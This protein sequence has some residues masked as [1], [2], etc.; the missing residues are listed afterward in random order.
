MPVPLH[1]DACS[2]RVL[3]NDRFRGKTVACP[4]CGRP[5]R[6]SS[7]STSVNPSKKSRTLQERENKVAR[8]AGFLQTVSTRMRF[9][10]AVFGV[11]LVVIS[12]VAIV[13]WMKGGHQEREAS[14]LVAV[15]EGRDVAAGRNNPVVEISD[16]QVPVDDESTRSD[17][18][19]ALSSVELKSDD[20]DSESSD[21]GEV[22]TLNDTTGP[23]ES[24]VPRL[25]TAGSPRPD[26]VRFRKVPLIDHVT[27]MAMSE[28]GSVLLTLHQSS[29]QVS[30]YDVLL[31]KVVAV[32]PTPSPRSILIRGDKAYV[33]NG[34]EP[35][36]RVYSRSKDWQEVARLPIS[37]KNIVH[38]SAA[39][40]PFFDGELLV[41][42][43]GDDRNASYRDAAV[44][45]LDSNTRDVSR[46]AA[47]S[48]ASVSFDG[49]TVLTQGSFNLSPSGGIGIYDHDE[50]VF[51]DAN[52]ISKGGMLQ[53]PFLSQ[54]LPG[55]YWTA[56]TVVF[57]GTPI[58]PVDADYGRLV[59]PDLSQRVIY[60]LHAKSLHALELNTKMTELGSRPVFYPSPFDEFERVYH[61]LYRT[62][63]YLLDHPVAYTHGERTC[64]FVLCA[65]GGVVLAAETSA[66]RQPKSDEFAQMIAEAKTNALE[67][68]TARPSMDNKSATESPGGISSGEKPL[69]DDVAGKNSAESMDPVPCR[70]TC[71]C[72]QVSRRA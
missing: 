53:T 54:V 70:A 39:R 51:G 66:M 1:C 8:P 64:L 19:D 12:T 71:N 49:R 11:V 44:F 15:A 40:G 43:H 57:S 38:L 72:A 23:Q 7:P 63:D 34:A 61:H 25:V 9:G 33:A 32:F 46:V 35:S 36:V 17:S 28:D 16:P 29:N 56:N 26:E 31:S 20:R 41:T 2:Y 4:Q 37:G 47:A 27:S 69:E 65:K 21:E 22:R 67:S 58:L 55:S 6:L 62:R 52:P 13:N 48:V 18:P 42:C 60:T 50:F 3:V 68:S 30:V 5:V 59:V 45:R 10:A 24:E 14:S